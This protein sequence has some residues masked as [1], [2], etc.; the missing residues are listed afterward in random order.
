LLSELLTP[1]DANRGDN[2]VLS[3]IDKRW[4]F[5]SLLVLLLA[6]GGYL[7][8]SRWINSPGH[9]LASA[10]GYYDRA[11]KARA[12][13]DTASA[14][15]NLESADTQLRNLLAQP[16]QA[17][18]VSAL[19]LRYHTLSDLAPL[20]AE[21]EGPAASGGRSTE[22]YNQGWVCVE[23]VV[24]LD[25]NHAQAH[26]QVMLGQLL[27]GRIV[28]A[29]PF[30]KRL[31]NLGRGENSDGDWP[32]YAADQTTA[33]FVL[34]WMALNQAQPPRPEE[35]L[36]LLRQADVLTAEATPSG[37]RPPAP[38][39]RAVALEARA[40]AL[41]ADQYK[42]LD[43]DGRSARTGPEL[44]EAQERLQTRL[45]GW[46]E[47]AKAEAAEPLPGTPV[48]LP[49][50]VHTVASLAVRYSP[51]DLP[52][53]L[54]VLDL[55]VQR[56]GSP[57][58]V[59][60]RL[61]LDLVVCDKLTAAEKT[62][63][64]VLRDVPRHLARA[65][66]AAHRRINHLVRSEKKVAANVLRTPA[67]SG[68]CERLDKLG[69]H[70]LDRQ[71]GRD[72]DGYLALARTAQ[73]TGRQAAA[74]HL[75]QRGLEA[76]AK[77]RA[78]D[79]A[80]ADRLA[81]TE[82]TLH[83]VAAWCYLV[84]NN[85]AT[86]RDQLTAVRKSPERPLGA[87]LHLLEGLLALQEGR[88]DAAARELEQARQA[89]A[90]A[91]SLYP[92]LGLIHA[93]M[94]L[95]KYDQALANLDRVR[96]ILEKAPHL[97]AD[98]QAAADWLLPN[99]AELN[100][101]Y[102][103]C[104]LGLGNLEQA[105]AYKEHLTGLPEGK[106]ATVLLVRACLARPAGKDVEPIY[107]AARKDLAVARMRA[108]DDPVY[109]TAEAE[110]LLS[111]PETNLPLAAGVVL[112]LAAGP[113]NLGVQ[114]LAN[115]HLRQ[116]LS[117]NVEK[118]EQ[119]LR[120]LAGRSQDLSTQLTWARWLTLRG[121]VTEADELLRRLEEGKG[122]E[123]RRRIQLQ[124]AL[125]LLSRGPSPEVA[126]LV[127][128]LGVGQR[129]LRSDLL[130]VYYAAAVTGNR[131]E[132]EQ[133][134]T[135]AFSRHGNSGLLHFWKGQLAEASGDFA[136]AARAYAHAL[137]FT[138]LRTP[139]QRG[140]LQSLINLSAKE[141]PRAAQQLAAELLQ[142]RP[143]EPSL[144][145]ATAESALLLDDF[146]GMEARLRALEEVLREL[147]GQAGA[148]AYF[149]ARAWRAAGRPDRARAE[150]DR[151]LQVSPRDPRIL[152]LAG[153]LAREAADWERCLALA[154]TL[155]GIMPEL[156]DP[157]LWRAAALERLGR[158][159]E[160]RRVCQRLVEKFP[161]R[162]EGYLGLAR[163]LEADKNYA[164]ALGWVAAWRERAP[165]EPDGLR[166]HVRLLALTGHT[167]EAGTRAEQAVQDAAR[168]P[169]P[170]Q[171]TLLE[172][173]LQLAAAMGFFSARA[174]DEAEQWA[175]RAEATAAKLPEGQRRDGL[176]TANLVIA[177][178]H[179]RR[180]QQAQAAAK[181][182]ELDEAIRGYRAV[183]ELAPGHPLAGNNLAWLLSQER[184]AQAEA[185]AVLRQVCQGRYSQQPLSGDRLPLNLLNTMGT[186]FRSARRNEEAVKLF[187]EA[188]QR[189]KEEPRVFLQL[190]R[191]YVG[192]Q[193]YQA[194]AENLNRAA[195]L[196]TAQME[197]TPDRLRKAELQSVLQEVR[198][199][200][201]KLGAD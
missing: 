94:G 50:T 39:W 183:L 185:L 84:Q 100:L 106:V 194:A 123:E 175:R 184:D 101:E 186:V 143:R 13:G 19:M 195:R 10:Q 74:L 23:R 70:C 163:L 138:D 201:S 60:T 200:Q 142:D 9:L 136:Q 151:A 24:G 173:N 153:D 146:T 120:E 133:R 199:D 82:A 114:A 35:A 135:R 168:E 179:L 29:A 154:A 38:R 95:A 145:L 170:A 65:G 130:G 169:N 182:Q 3:R 34:A 158:T 89:P 141:S 172:E 112:S 37:E 192:L 93:Y 18:N 181:Q 2:D 59:L 51:T 190:A 180:S 91:E 149:R 11:E 71:G 155:E 7:A 188:S 21:E 20:V 126:Q 156:P 63:E 152:L 4:L 189:Y 196:A 116:A 75:A 177:E 115:W 55:A 80:A 103:R 8:Y 46:L 193:Q 165:T 27:R 99:E 36:E 108:P 122:D 178:V 67:W 52:G 16:G 48:T 139:A 140:V 134:L 124:R 159:D 72:A 147:P 43:T 174:H 197:S 128:A 117:W 81:R 137:A 30:A 87:Q 97:G 5:L 96:H 64:P 69:E 28:A 45:A 187:Q 78:A 77:V 83:A 132:A 131:T 6:G 160:A 102:F 119:V 85:V 56:A 12:A 53:L 125:V 150:I 15:L 66:D 162:S 198:Q 32:N 76:V 111:R 127:D 88:L 41:L 157:L 144:L 129:D 98:A 104:Y 49:I 105:L 90:V 166:A 79:P 121:R 86:A 22:L 17:N 40:L 62:P 191:S 58:D 118:A 54:D 26:V 31:V 107:Q 25:P 14:R 92:Y 113:A 109:A 171:A 110:L 68:L 161:D 42:Q 176:I 47:R 164:N 148:G 44:R 167:A 1:E 57:A 33:R 61:D 73:G